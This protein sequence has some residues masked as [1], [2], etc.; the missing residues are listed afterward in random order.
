MFFQVEKNVWKLWDF[1][2]GVKIEVYNLP[3]MSSLPELYVACG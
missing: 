2:G 1:F 3:S